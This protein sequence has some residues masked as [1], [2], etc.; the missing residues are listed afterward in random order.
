MHIQSKPLYHT[1]VMGT[2]QLSAGM[3]VLD[4][5]LV[6]TLLEVNEKEEV[7]VA[8]HL[9]IGPLKSALGWSRYRDAIPV[10]YLP[11]H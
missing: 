7:V 8:L 2:L 5:R 10:A 1:P 3:S 11:A 4:S 9:P 6:V